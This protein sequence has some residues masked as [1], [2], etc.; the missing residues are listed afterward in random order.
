MP[1]GLRLKPAGAL[2]LR[3]KVSLSPSTSVAASW[4]PT[5]GPSSV[6]PALVGLATGASLTGDTLTVAV[7]LVEVA[8]SLSTAWY[9]KVVVPFQSLS[10]TK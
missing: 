5:V 8:P 10:G 6:A 3:L 9:W 2:P 4:P 1:S 7:A